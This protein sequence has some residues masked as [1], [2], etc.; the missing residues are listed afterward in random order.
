MKNDVFGPL[1]AVLTRYQY[2]NNCVNSAIIDL[3]EYVKLE[4]I[5]NII[6]HVG[7]K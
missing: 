3:L 4:N 5:R 6:R 2:Q 7:D 1:M